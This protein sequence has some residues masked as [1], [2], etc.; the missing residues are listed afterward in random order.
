MLKGLLAKHTVAKAVAA[1]AAVAAARIGDTGEMA[2][3]SSMKLKSYFSATVEAALELARRELG[4]DALLVNAR[5]STPET[6]SLGAFEVVFGVM[7]V[8]P[9]QKDAESYRPTRALLAAPE[10]EFHDAERLAQGASDLALTRDV[11]GLRNEIERMAYSLRA[12]Q[13]SH[14]VTLVRNPAIYTSLL[15][16]ELDPELAR[17]VA[18][19][20][21]LEGLI[22]VDPTL[23][24]PEAARAVV[25]LVGPP[26]AGKTTALIKLAARYGLSGRK[27]CHII[28]TDVQRVAA[29]DQLRTLAAILGIG[30]TIV[31]T[32]ASLEQVLE[33]HRAKEMIFVDTPGLARD[34]M[35]EGAELARFTA[36]HSEFD[37]HLVLPA[38]LKPFDLAAVIDRYQMFAP[39]KLLFTRIDETSR[40]GALIS[41]S[42]KRSLPVSFLATG[43]QIPDDLEPASKTRLGRLLASASSAPMMLSRTLSKSRG[44]S[45]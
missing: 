43:Q 14:A 45:A 29:A 19:G 10:A 18:D 38:W 16:A 36:S 1:R 20:A 44:A 25:M 42:A 2:K 31:E 7:P 33:E 5:P 32:A 39:R 13:S 26:G 11:A 37:T 28:S 35:Q 40:F 21:P 27:P 23:G 6:R 24:R 4:G 17:Q 22:E 30:C 9:E 34:E 8:R 12:M 3:S 15:E 41:E